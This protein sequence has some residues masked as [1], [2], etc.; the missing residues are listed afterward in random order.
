M[1]SIDTA[2]YTR[3]AGFAGLSALV[4]TRIY[5]PPAPQNCTYPAVTFMQ[6]SGMRDYVMG[7]QS[8]LVEAR[9]Q[10]DSWAETSVGVRTLAEQVRL[11]L[12]NYSGTSDTIVIDHIRLLDE[13]RI[14]EDGDELFRI[15]QD[16]IVNYRETLPS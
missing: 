3:L 13:Q 9:F 12:S 6:I 11:A 16:Y 4:S 8:G 7:N 1:A 15:I 10:L 2:I 5:P 14:Y